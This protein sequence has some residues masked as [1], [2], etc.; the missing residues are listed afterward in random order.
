MPST[1]E[2]RRRIKSVKSIGQVTRAMEMIAASRMRRAQ[3][4]V[5]AG[6]PYSDKIDEVLSHLA[7]R[8][9][10]ADELHP[11]LDQRPIKRVLVV[12]VTSDRG[13]AGAFST[14]IIRRAT[15]LMLDETS[16]ESQIVAI[17][18]K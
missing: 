16:A 2:I 6:R 15:R 18:R 8:I 5:L 4:A 11:L 3:Q 12:L 9:R 17:G 1:R 7:A 14:N 10:G 13:L